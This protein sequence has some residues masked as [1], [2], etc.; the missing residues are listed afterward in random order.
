LKNFKSFLIFFLQKTIFEFQKNSS[1]FQIPH[2]NF[3]K[4]LR[5]RFL[6]LGHRNSSISYLSWNP[7]PIY[8]D[9]LILLFPIHFFGRCLFIYVFRSYIFI[10]TQKKSREKSQFE[11]KR[12]VFYS[13]GE[14]ATS[15]NIKSQ[16]FNF[17]T[18]QS[19]VCLLEFQWKAI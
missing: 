18:P 10:L 6:Y 19:S 15:S 8:S 5:Q 14:P 12:E 16:I 7:I 2:K 17:N 4:S 1:K 13:S 9:R 11:V 3:S